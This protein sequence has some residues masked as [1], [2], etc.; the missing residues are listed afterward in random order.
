M[1]NASRSKKCMLMCMGSIQLYE[2]ICSYKC[3]STSCSDT[4]G[5]FYHRIRF[6]QLQHYRLIL[7]SQLD[8]LSSRLD[9]RLW[10]QQRKIRTGKTGV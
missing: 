2:I 6:V 9:C 8:F 10:K 4:I 3:F 5:A 1:G 7:L